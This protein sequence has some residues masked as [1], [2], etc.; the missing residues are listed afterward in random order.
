M[1]KI[2]MR[3]VT[4]VI[5]A[6]LALPVAAAPLEVLT[7]DGGPIA[8]PA[9][10]HGQ[11][12]SQETGQAVTVRTRPFDALYGEIMMGFVT[13]QVPADLLI[14]PADWL[15][16][17]APYLQPVPEALVQGPLVQG[18]HPAY[19]DGLMRWR[20][21]WMAVTLDGDLHM[22]AYRRDL[23]EDPA[24][25]ADYL[26]TTGTPLAPPQTWQDYTRIATF[27]AGRSGPEGQ[28]LAGALEASASN[29]QRLWSLFSHAAAY[30]AHPDHP[31]HFFF[32]P[33]TMTPEIDNPAWQRALR[34]YLAAVATGVDESGPLASHGVRTAFA[35]G[36]GAMALDWSDIGVLATDPKASTVADKVGFFPLPGADEVWN[37]QTQ[38]WDRLAAPQ[39]VPFLAFGGWI[40]AVPRG[41]QQPQTAWDFI[42]YMAAPERAARDVMSGASGF[43][44]YRL[45]QLDDATGW[46]ALMGP[47]AAQN[48]LR[49]L[50][51]SL[52]APH[53]AQDLRLPG[54]P[55]YMEALDARI[56]KV[57]AKEMTPEEALH[58]ASAEWDRI[59]DRLG[60]TSQRRHY[61]EAMGLE[62]AQP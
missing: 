34:D 9:R 53:A 24:T 49:V 2:A 62:E 37:P 16:D 13:G 11:S 43:N 61:R 42:A 55:A 60:R 27:F 22:G 59:T 58:E 6:L 5:L 4:I 21:Q 30:T 32:D 29:G 48:Y 7:R 40:A 18:I 45:S 28:P 8:G 15:P 36:Q 52:N 54:Y 17:F 23:F 44:P 1:S 14:F 57:L 39:S 38:S 51:E 12:F 10:A 41:A 35:A 19:R 25:R 33:E 31:G 3:F 50:R 56:G 47:R 20:G 46:A 26:A